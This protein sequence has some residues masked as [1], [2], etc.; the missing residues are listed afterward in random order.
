MV[1]VAAPVPGSVPVLRIRPTAAAAA[2][3]PEDP[4]YLPADPANLLRADPGRRQPVR[5]K[6]AGLMLAGDLYRPRGAAAAERTPGIVM[7]GPFSSVKE[8]T[9]PHYAERFADAGYTVL[10]FDPRTFGDSEGEPRQHHIP[11]EVIDDFASGV[12]YLMGRSDIDPERVA[13][14]GVCLGG[15]YA[16]HVGALDKRVRAVASIA[17]GF[18]T[19]GTFQQFMG[20]DAYAG[21]VGQINAVLMQEYGDNERRY[22]PVTAPGI[23]AE[24]PLVAMPNAEAYSY[25]TRTGAADAPRWQN[26]ITVSSLHH[27]LMFNAVAHAALVAPAPLLIIHGTT[28]MVLLPELAQQAYDAAV[29]PKELIW[30]DTH[31]HIELYDHDPYVSIAAARTIAW[32][33]RQMGRQQPAAAENVALSR[34]AAA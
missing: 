24:A 15:G 28:D 34:G 31:N 25:Y 27:F 33:D 14:V 23:T 3:P 16:V 18:S 10:T 8:Q 4:H 12:N 21:Y 2:D 20:V 26:R 17:G 29:G 5:F 9:L 32:L 1:T 11:S 22:I 6:S 19:G 30:I 13:V 7:C